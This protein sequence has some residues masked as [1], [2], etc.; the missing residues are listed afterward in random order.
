MSTVNYSFSRLNAVSTSFFMR[1]AVGIIPFLQN[2][3]Q[4][5]PGQL[6]DQNLERV[7]VAGVMSWVMVADT[8]ALNWLPVKMGHEANTKKDIKDLPISCRCSV[9]GRNNIDLNAIDSKE[10]QVL[11]I[12]NH[13]QLVGRKSRVGDS[14][15]VGRGGAHDC[16]GLKDIGRFDLRVAAGSETSPDIRL[17]AIERSSGY[18]FLRWID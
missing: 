8:L 9:C 11:N 2:S 5:T 16:N 13:I 6:E 7:G 14:R 12:Q 4:T 3:G 10:W 1:R 18:C 15:S 17:I